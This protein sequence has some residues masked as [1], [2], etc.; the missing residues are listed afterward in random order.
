LTQNIKNTIINLIKFSINRIKCQS[1]KMEERTM[2]QKKFL[3]VVI[4]VLVLSTMLT[5]LFSG[6]KKETNDKTD[7]SGGSKKVKITMLN[8][9]NE[10]QTALVDGAKEF[11]KKY[12]NVELSISLCPAGQSPFEKLS[13]MTASGNA[14]TIA[15]IEGGD[16]AKF[17]S[18]CVDLSNEKWV[19]DTQ[20]GM[21]D[22]TK[23]KDGKIIAFPLTIEGYGVIY[24]KAVLSK[25]NV[26]PTSIKTR[27]DFDAALKKVKESLGAEPLELSPMDWSLGNHFLPVGYVAQDKDNAKV[28]DFMTSMKDGK[29]KLSSN[30]A[31]N[32]V[33][34]TFDMMKNYNKNKKDPLPETYEKGAEAIAKGTVGFWFMGNWA[35]PEIK[36]SGNP[37]LGFIPLPISDKAEDYGN[38]QIPIGVT[39][40][41]FIDKDQNNADQQKAAKDFLNWLVYDNDGQKVMVEKAAIV[42]AF[43]NISIDPP[44]PLGKDLKK[45]MNENKAMKFMSVLPADHWKVLGADF[46][47]YFVGKQKRDEFYKAIEKYWA[48]KKG[49]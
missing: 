33:L 22:D 29:V 3:S 49:Q 1:K 42:P 8:S 26:D 31:M 44:D 34:D 11:Q 38:T 6:C 18:K 7:S 12:P 21:L 32:G 14:P 28:T 48:G 27:K 9:K 10:I 20:T 24:N 45:Y 36:K 25:A 23:S 5:S 43:K 17:E 37:E 40:F 46:Q 47:K 15:V 19:S 30:T 39:K 4:S 41:A 13:S 35:W 16:L 2:K